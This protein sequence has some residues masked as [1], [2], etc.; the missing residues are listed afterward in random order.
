MPYGSCDEMI[1]LWCCETRNFDPE[2]LVAFSPFSDI[3]F[4]FFA[5]EKKMTDVWVGRGGAAREKKKALAHARTKFLK[6]NITKKKSFSL[7][8]SRLL[9]HKLYFPI[10][11]SLFLLIS[12]SFEL[13]S[14]FQMHLKKKK[15]IDTPKPKPSTYLTVGYIGSLPLTVEKCKRFFF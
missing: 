3:S 4:F 11:A 8:A 7:L 1:R 9:T 14:S 13:F 12:L 6:N 15:T 10:S 5:V 2:H